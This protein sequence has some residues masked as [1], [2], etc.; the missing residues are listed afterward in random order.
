MAV[1]LDFLKGY[2]I[3]GNAAVDTF[4][5]AL[6]RQRDALADDKLT[7]R[8]WAKPDGKGYRI[9]LGKL[10]GEYSLPSKQEATEFFHFIAS[11]ARSDE[12]FKALVEAAYGTPLGEE[13]AV[14]KPRKARTPKAKS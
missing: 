7:R 12:D 2:E 3:K 13:P 6:E 9:T 10:D 8:S 5:T 11:E 1:L 14:K 4:M